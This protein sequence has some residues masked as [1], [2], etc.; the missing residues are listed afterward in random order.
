MLSF[1]EEEHSQSLAVACGLCCAREIGRSTA[2]F[3][4][5][6]V[7]VDFVGFLGCFASM[8][9]RLTSVRNGKVDVVLIKENSRYSL[10]RCRPLWRILCGE[11]A[12]EYVRYTL[13]GATTTTPSQGHLQC[14]V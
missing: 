4:C 1:E 13:G 11:T 12:V 8:G 10:G 14:P 5:C 3:L 2:M 6:L 7:P 9:V